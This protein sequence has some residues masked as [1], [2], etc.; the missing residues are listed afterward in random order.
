MSAP[1]R[2]KI[3][4]LSVEL[5]EQHRPLVSDLRRL[6]KSLGLEFG[7]HYLLDLAWIIDNLGAVNGKHILDA[8]AGMG[9]LQ[10]YLAERGAEVL[11]VDRA[12][13]AD[14]PT[15]FRRRYHAV[16]LRPADLSPAGQSFWHNIGRVHGLRSRASLVGRAIYSRLSP[17]PA[18]GRVVFYQQDLQ[19][20]E[21]VADEALDAVVAVS[22]LEH[23]PPPALGQV[24]KELMR[25]IKPGGMFLATL[26]AARDLDWYHQ[27]SSGWCYTEASLR[28]AFYL[29]DQAPS[30]YERY[31]ELFAALR[32]CAELR[33]GLARFYFRS[34]ENG[35]PWGRWEPQYQPV[36]VCKVKITK[37]RGNEQYA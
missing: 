21:A 22:A 26:A 23:N 9:V 10:W 30:N 15:H 36:G 37:I 3:E 5:L 18:P 13:R 20:L 2:D 6:A 27:P 29:P 14:L 32:D 33:E 7:W 19:R 35:M 17:R 34:G 4:I 12:S 24:V 8:G 16:G 1:C 11:S 28:Q 25:V 31:D